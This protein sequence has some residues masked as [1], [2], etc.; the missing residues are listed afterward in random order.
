MVIRIQNGILNSPNPGFLFKWAV[1]KETYGDDLGFRLYPNHFGSHLFGN[2]QHMGATPEVQETGETSLTNIGKRPI[3]L[4][5][6][7]SRKTCRIPASLTIPTSFKQLAKKGKSVP[8]C[9][10]LIP[11]YAS[12]PHRLQKID[13][14]QK[15]VPQGRFGFCLNER[16]YSLESSLQSISSNWSLWKRTN[17]SP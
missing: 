2:E 5:R 4:K 16:A 12:S 17:F 13:R 15:N 3:Y 10:D 9:L 6:D 14:G 7:S 8:E 1:W 11:N